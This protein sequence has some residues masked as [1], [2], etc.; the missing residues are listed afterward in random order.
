[1]TS[2]RLQVSN[3]YYKKAY[4]WDVL[5]LSSLAYKV[6]N[7]LGITRFLRMNVWVE[8]ESILWPSLFNSDIILKIIITIT[9]LFSIHPIPIYLWLIPSRPI[10][11]VS[12]SSGKTIWGYKNQLKLRLHHNTL[13]IFIFKVYKEEIHSPRILLLFNQKP[14]FSTHHKDQFL[15]LETSIIFHK[16]GILQAKEVYL[17]KLMAGEESFRKSKEKKYKSTGLRD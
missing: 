10:T 4:G 2:A 3:L 7:L 13:T 14:S 16:V 12:F 15:L 6:C 1:M 5:P 8:V 9:G 11:I 17:K